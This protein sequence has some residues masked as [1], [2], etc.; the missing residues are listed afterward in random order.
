MTQRQ[1]TAFD[2]DVEREMHDPAYRAA[3]QAARSQIDAIDALLRELDA[4]RE[5]QSLSKADLA[6]RM[7]VTPEAIRRLFS[8]DTPNPTMKTVFGVATALGY[9]VKIEPSPTH[10]VAA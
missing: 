3:H 1:K 9:R 4:A 7:G 6:R 5:A 2:L 10:P 8:A